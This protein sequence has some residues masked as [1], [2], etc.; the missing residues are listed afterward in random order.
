M[1]DKTGLEG[2]YDI[3]LFIPPEMEAGN[4][5]LD[6]S[7]RP[8]VNPSVPT[9]FDSLE[10]QLGLKVETQLAPVEMLVIDHLEPVPTG[11]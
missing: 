11:N 2:Y 10:K 1:V 7:G 8:P 6:Q 3:N 5:S 9:Y 4:S